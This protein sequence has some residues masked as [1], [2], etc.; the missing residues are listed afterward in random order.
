RNPMLALAETLEDNRK[1]W[2]DLPGI[3]WHY[4]VTKLKPAAL[5]LLVHPRLKAEQDPMPLAAMHYYGKGLV[6]FLGFEETWRWR[7]NTQDQVFG[8][9]WGQVIYQLGLP[10]TLGTRQTQFALERSEMQVGQPGQVYA[11]LFDSE[12]R[13]LTQEQ[14]QAQLERLEGP[15]GSKSQSLT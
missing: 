3:Y 12:F 5:S 15:P 6:L 11:R 9:C 13:P 14:V 1:V 7:Y 8:R 2:Q 10:H 4:P